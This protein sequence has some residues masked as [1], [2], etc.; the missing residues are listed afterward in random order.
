MTES[1]VAARIHKIL[2][3][4][5]GFLDTSKEGSH[6]IVLPFKAQHLWSGGLTRSRQMLCSTDL[7]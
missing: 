7:P 4:Q 5:L 3:E 1:T 6:D 2:R